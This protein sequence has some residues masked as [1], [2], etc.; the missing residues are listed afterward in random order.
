MVTSDSGPSKTSHEESLGIAIGLILAGVV[1][2]WAPD[3]LQP[4]LGWKAFWYILG[5]ILG[6]IGMGGALFELSELHGRPGLEDWAVASVFLGAAGMLYALEAT[7][8]VAGVWSS[9]FKILTVVLGMIA[10]LGFGIGLGNSLAGSRPRRDSDASLPKEIGAGIIALLGFAT[11]ILNF[12]AA[13][14]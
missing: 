3:Y 7:G 6:T 8:V 10:A 14:S 2:F 11:A 12:L 4:T 1:A 13:G 9:G 5:G